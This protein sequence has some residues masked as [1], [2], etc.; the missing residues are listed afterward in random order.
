MFDFIRTHQ[1]LMQLVLLVLILPSFVLIGVSGY[2]NYVSGDKDLVKVGDSA[3]T[4]QEFEL[5]RRNQLEQM[6][7][8]SMGRFDPEVLNNRAARE[9]LLE[10]L[11]D[12]RILVDTATRERFS[13]SDAVLRNS[14]ASMPE[15]QENG[16]FSAERYNQLL[17]S[18]GL[19]TRDFEQGQRGELALQRV[20]GP[21]GTTAQLPP[22]VLGRIAAALTEDRKVR[23]Q[24][25]SASD[26]EKEVVVSEADVQAWYDKNKESLTV[27][28]QV[29]VQYLLLDEAVAMAA[30]GDIPEADL[31]AYYEQNKSRYVLPA[32][33]DVSHIQISVPSSA[34]DADR[35]AARTR[36]Q[37]IARQVKENPAA[38][39]DIARKESQDAGTAREGGHL[40]WVTAGSW[41]QPLES[42]VFAL[43]QGQV[44]DV[45]EGPAGFH[46]FI[47]NRVEPEKGETF[48]EARPKVEQEVRRQLASERFAELATR[49][50][51]LVY[52]NSTSLEPAAQALGVQLRTVTGVTRDGLLGV[53]DAGD[54]AAAASPDAAIFEDVRVRSTL[55]TPALLQEK[56]NSGVIEISPDTMVVV[57]V[58]SFEPAHVPALEQ[59]KGRVEAILV[60]ERARDAAVAEGEKRLT[61]LKEAPADAGVP[62]G[63]G[64]PLTISRIDSQGVAK[65][66]LDA[67]FSVAPEKV[68]T[69]VGVSGPR[70]YVIARVESVTPGEVDS[71]LLAGLGGE[72][73]RAWGQAEERAVLQ[74]MRR[75][76]G[77]K[78]TVDAEAVLEGK[79]GE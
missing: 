29:A 4:L 45:V 38:F 16:R 76:A 21:V 69:Y 32:R 11:V 25:F 78:F 70:G 72:L 58:A 50:T 12:R 57:R 41:P 77:V 73:S 47:A 37:E 2:T 3:V 60:A 54:Q 48:D 42:A 26:H 5:A 71:L 10:S 62:D 35:E 20:L 6:Q 28:D 19:T 27:P 14:I 68:P 65:A 53:E 66:V 56:A 23:L 1:R 51:D 22:S 46:V 49:L 33:V 40:G 8:S 17:S 43:A 63:F 30:V 59:V 79:N 75:E 24:A 55:F 52:D 64:E 31:K 36:A 13:V 15:F 34:S 39:A 9:M 67:V 44:S 7:R 18:A 74:E 61:A